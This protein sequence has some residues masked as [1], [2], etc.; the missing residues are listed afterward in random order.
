MESSDFHFT[1]TDDK[2]VQNPSFPDNYVSEACRLA[3]ENKHKLVLVSSHAVVLKEFVARGVKPL[4]VC[5]P[6]SCK[7]QDEWVRRYVARSYNGFTLDTLQD[8][9]ML[10]V[11][12]MHSMARNHGLPVITIGTSGYIS[13]L[14]Y[15]DG[16]HVAKSLGT[17]K[18][19]IQLSPL[20]ND[21]ELLLLELISK[22]FKDTIEEYANNSPRIH[23][24]TTKRFAEAL[25]VYMSLHA[26]LEKAVKEAAD[27]RR[28]RSASGRRTQ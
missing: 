1:G 23:T 19:F 15:P 5:P 27:T 21:E 9:Y 4:L 13:D 17:S 10:W 6:F 28:V 8:N 18:E 26:K 11:D 22:G 7:G 2:K 14:I 20:T 16:E 12:D 3:A 24:D 25:G